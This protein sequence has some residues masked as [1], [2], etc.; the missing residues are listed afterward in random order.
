MALNVKRGSRRLIVAA[1]VLWEALALPVFLWRVW[2]W[3]TNPFWR[4]SPFYPGP[5]WL[6]VVH[7]GTLA[8]GCP[9][10]AA[11]I[12]VAGRRVWVGFNSN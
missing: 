8:I 5:S 1:F 6:S 4:F 3:A 11:V 2:E 7:W 9:L 10:A 12:L